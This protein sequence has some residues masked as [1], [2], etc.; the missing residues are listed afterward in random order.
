ME[1]KKIQAKIIKYL[2]SQGIYVVKN[3]IANRSGIPDLLLCY[4]GQ[5]MAIEVKKDI[6][7]I[8]SPLQKW[9]R[10]EIIKAGGKAYT[11]RSLEE[12]KQIIEP[13]SGG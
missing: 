3:I 6:G 7:G 4:R 9:N 13:I 5:F 11:V 10:G 12:V 1:E 2:K 8:E